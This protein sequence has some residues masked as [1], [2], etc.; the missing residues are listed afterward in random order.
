MNNLGI[1]ELDLPQPIDAKKRLF[2][3]RVGDLLTKTVESIPDNKVTR[4]VGNTL[5]LSQMNALTKTLAKAEEGIV[6]RGAQ[7]AKNK[8]NIDPRVAAL[9]LSAI[10]PGVVPNEAK[11]I[12]NAA[13]LGKVNKLLK[14]KVVKG[15]KE[16][17]I[18]ANQM[19]QLKTQLQDWLKKEY[20]DKGKASLI[21]RQDFGTIIVD[22]EPRQISQITQFLERGGKLPFPPKVVTKK[23]HAFKRLQNTRPPKEELT[24]LGKQL[25][26]NQSQINAYIKEAQ[27]G[28][29]DVQEAARR[30]GLTI[31]QLKQE[32]ITGKKTP[33]T[34]YTP[35]A[36]HAGHFWPAN[37]GGAT[38]R[39]TAGVEPGK[40]NIGKKDSFEG[41]INLYAAQKAG[42]PTTWAEDMKMWFRD[43][44]GLPGPRY[45]E[46]FNNKQRKIIE[47][48][49]WDATEEQVNAIW[50]QRKLDEIPNVEQFQAIKDEL[51][52]KRTTGGLQI[53]YDRR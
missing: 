45:A 4:A 29:G 28:F 25:G 12:K 44:K 3:E 47:S 40:L 50:K 21:K 13:K 34:E 51:T 31:K 22:A 43:K 42:I 8:L 30:Q 14:P 2:G 17:N 32:Y 16:W 19:P 35:G 38:S 52:S 53:G 5:D 20:A 11:A 48:I 49:P 37:K 6:N 15:V 27:D 24:T 1:E 7:F 18:K 33:R 9:G 46:D 10:I 41:T 36:Y 23:A 26:L 39:R